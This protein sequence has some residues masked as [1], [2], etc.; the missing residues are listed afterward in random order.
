MA[1]ALLTRGDHVRV[2]DNLEPQVHGLAQAWPGY[3]DARVERV[4]GD[5]RSRTA[6]AASLGGIDCVYHLAAA[7]GVGQS[8]YQIAKYSAVNVQGTANLLDVLANERHGVRRLVLA[9]SR[10]V[11]GEGAYR[12]AVCGVVHPTVRTA[13]QLDQAAWEPACPDC[14]GECSP[15]ATP[16][17][18]AP[19][20]GSIYAVT[21]LAQERMCACFGEAYGMPV[22]ILRLF[23]VYGPRQALGNPY[24][25]IVT[26][27]ANR[28][29]AG[30][31]PEVYEDGMMTRDFVHVCDVV[32]ALE[33]A[34]TRDGPPGGVYNVGSGRATTVLELARAMCAD[35]APGLE[36]EISGRARVG[37]VRHCTA[38]TERAADAFGLGPCIPL[39]GALAG[40][41]R[42]CVHGDPQNGVGAR[43][44][45]AT[46]GLVRLYSRQARA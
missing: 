27:F 12:C 40:L 24:T 17:T 9:S 16:E 25:G 43:R 36:P 41:S 46:R 34:G 18:L 4:R 37:D 28:L 7:T 45:L 29:L 32:R 3:L 1:D 19:D 35:L 20:P 22:V 11:Y 38:A 31:P 42:C 13:A 30:E 10:A 2:F 21:K 6:L 5:V 39:G 23:N 44:E 14:G 8:M 33:R 26:V 15:I